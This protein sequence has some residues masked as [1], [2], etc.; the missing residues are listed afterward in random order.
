MTVI[1]GSNTGIT[2]PDNTVTVASDITSRFSPGI[3][4]TGNTTTLQS[5]TGVVGSTGVLT[6]G[7]LYK[8][9]RV[10]QSGLSLWL[11][12][13]EEQSYP[14]SGDTWFDLSGNDK[15][16]TLTN[17]AVYSSDNFGTMV[18]DG[19]NDYA[20]IPALSGS[21]TSFSINVDRKSVV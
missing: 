12:A 20:L 2:F 11:D 3:T 19:T 4:S 21:F 8:A 10:I 6:N 5:G 7:T 14:G 16:A 13:A 18:F 17:G 15:D 1:V 9:S